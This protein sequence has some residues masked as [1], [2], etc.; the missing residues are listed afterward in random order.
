MYKLGH[1]ANVLKGHGVKKGDRVT[2]GHRLNTS[3]ANQRL[4]RA[5]MNENGVGGAGHLSEPSRGRSC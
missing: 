4:W 5:I 3:A 2:Q 1:F